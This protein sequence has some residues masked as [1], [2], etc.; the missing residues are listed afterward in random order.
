MS[1]LIRS[2]A[3]MYAGCQTLVKSI[4]S[5][6][7]DIEQV[8]IA[9][10]FGSKIDIENA[11]TIGLMPDLPRDRFIFIGNGSLLGARLTSFSGDL[12][13]DGQRIAAM[14]TNFELSENADFMANYTAALFLPHT[15]AEDFPSVVIN[16]GK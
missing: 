13:K 14:M 11:I 15:H 4:G 5:R 7:A 1:N 16:K 2:K 6:C 12:L 8:I 10:T 3:A 9:G